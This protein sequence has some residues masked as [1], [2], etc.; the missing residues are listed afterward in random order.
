MIE[1][2]KI[3]KISVFIIFIYIAFC[4]SFYYLGGEQIKIERKDTSSYVNVKNIT[5]ELLPGDYVSQPFTIDST[6][7]DIISFMATTFSRKN[8]SDLI[9]RINRKE[10]VLWEKKISTSNF[11]DFGINEIRLEKPLTIKPNEILHLVIFSDNSYPGNAIGI[12]FGDTI[13]AM[14]KEI[15]IRDYRKAVFN[16]KQIEGMIFYKIEGYKKLWVG[17]NFQLIFLGGLFILL[18]YLYYNYWCNVKYKKSRGLLF[19]SAVYKY[20]FLFEQVVKRDFKRKYKRSVLGILWSFFNPLLTMLIQYLIFSNLFNSDVKNYPIYLLSGVV[21]FSFISE[22]TSMALGSIVGNASLI[23]KI[24][25]PKYIYPVSSTLSSLVNFL[26]S[27]L[28]LLFMMLLSGTKITLSIILLPYCIVCMFFISLGISLILST[29]MVFFR[30]IQFLWG[31]F[32]TLWMYMTPIFYPETIIPENMLFLYR[33]N[34]LY[35]ILKFVRTIL[36]EGISPA[37]RTYMYCS[38]MSCFF[39]FMGSF[40]FKKSQDKFVLYI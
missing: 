5:E 15:K 4:L 17:Y 23:T 28:T 29:L 32:L 37:P 22:A 36:I 21:C 7:I 14:G 10:E 18:L 25:M 16:S 9:L 8:N 13:L 31:V 20:R 35:H 38:L 12:A 39:I 33:I 24:Y 6:Y 40:I 26:I 11:E 3:I 2:K 34:P 19:V 30:D 1:N 27:C